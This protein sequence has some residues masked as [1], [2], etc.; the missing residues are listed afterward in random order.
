MEFLTF[1]FLALTPHPLWTLPTF[2]EILFKASLIIFKTDW[3]KTKLKKS[4]PFDTEQFVWLIYGHHYRISKIWCVWSVWAD[5]LIPYM[6]PVLYSLQ[7]IGPAGI[8]SHKL[9]GPS[10]SYSV[11]Q[12]YTKTHFTLILILFI[13]AEHVFS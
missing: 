3:L 12:K 7:Y 5:Q 11:K 8:I 13:E 1:W 10:N 9:Y 6:A 2:C 4:I